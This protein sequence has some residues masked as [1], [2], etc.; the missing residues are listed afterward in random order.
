MPRDLAA[1]PKPARDSRPSTAKVSAA[2]IALV[3]AHPDVLNERDCAAVLAGARPHGL[4]KGVARAAQFGRFAHIDRA[5]LRAA[6][7][8]A[9]KRGHVVLGQ[10]GVLSPAV[11]PRPKRR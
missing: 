5:A 11:A 4:S 6:V 2:V 3:R 1:T 8:A 9:I 7:A 10:R